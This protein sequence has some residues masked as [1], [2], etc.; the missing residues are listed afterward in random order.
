M[1]L[2]N[3]NAPKPYKNTNDD[4][5]SWTNDCNSITWALSVRIRVRKTFS[6]LVFES[7]KDFQIKTNLKMVLVFY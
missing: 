1:S 6:K 5:A 2:K 4:T 3:I 7:S